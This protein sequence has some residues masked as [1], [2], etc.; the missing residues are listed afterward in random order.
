ADHAA[1]EGEAGGREARRAGGPV[2]DGRPRPSPPPRPEAAPMPKRR[3]LR[4]TPSYRR[5][6]HDRGR[7]V[8]VWKD[9]AGKRHRKALPGGYDSPESRAAFQ[10]LRRGVK[11]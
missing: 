3:K 1:T 7:A 6:R 8:A 4:L 5:D 2:R 9:A 10:E 11:A